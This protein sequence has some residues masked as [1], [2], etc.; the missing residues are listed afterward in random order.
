MSSIPRVV[1]S[2]R[3]KRARI[4]TG[5][6]EGHVRRFGTFRPFWRRWLLTAEGYPRVGPVKKLH[7]HSLG[8]SILETITVQ[9]FEPC[10]AIFR[11]G[12]RL[13][14]EFAMVPGVRSDHES[15]SLSG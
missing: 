9:P 11:A 14:L 13:S 8:G 7:V 12:C 5:V 3:E 6:P 2:T 1:R 4:E 10:K 15:L